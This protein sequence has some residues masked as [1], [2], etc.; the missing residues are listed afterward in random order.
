M[1]VA[2]VLGVGAAGDRI[3]FHAKG[4]GNR[5]TTTATRLPGLLIELL[6]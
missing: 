4:H 3:L 6:H 5:G 1:R 2:V